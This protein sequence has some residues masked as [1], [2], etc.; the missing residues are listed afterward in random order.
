MHNYKDK[1]C[2]TN[3][4]EEACGVKNPSG[5]FSLTI[6]FNELYKL[7]QATE[8]AG[9]DPYSQY[10]KMRKQQKR[11][12]KSQVHSSFHRQGD[13]EGVRGLM[14]EPEE[15]GPEEEAK[16]KKLIEENM[17]QVRRH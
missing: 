16:L 17:R 4:D 3:I 13:N 6:D 2:L 11:S 7:K 10:M 1:L 14:E 5:T 8:E 12:K 9:W 15:E